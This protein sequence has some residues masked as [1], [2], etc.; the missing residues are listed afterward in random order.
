MLYFEVIRTL[1]LFKTVVKFGYFAFVLRILLLDEFATYLIVG[2]KNI[3]GNG[4]SHKYFYNIYRNK[5][6]IELLS[7]FFEAVVIVVSQ[8][9]V[10]VC[11]TNT[12][13]TGSIETVLPFVLI[14]II[15]YCINVVK[16]FII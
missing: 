14:F 7:V 9:V 1:N 16:F 4:N 6:S 11:S 2:W 15:L 13:H 8:I 3:L 5:A 10:V 12:V